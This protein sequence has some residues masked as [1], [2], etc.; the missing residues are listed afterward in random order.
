MKF[1]I[2]SGCRLGIADG[3]SQKYG[4][5]NHLVNLVVGEGFGQFEQHLGDLPP[6]APFFVELGSVGFGE[7]AFVTVRKHTAQGWVGSDLVGQAD[8][9][10]DVPGVVSELFQLL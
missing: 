3:I 4:G 8:S 7:V 9:I 5:V 1:R 10:A 6:L 2:K